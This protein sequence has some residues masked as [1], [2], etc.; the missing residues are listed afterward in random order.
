MSQ[1]PTPPEAPNPPPK[2][3][4]SAAAA[5]AVVPHAP[6]SRSGLKNLWANLRAS[7]RFDFPGPVFTKE[8]RSSQRRFSA[9]SVRMVYVLILA[10]ILAIVY[11][12]TKRSEADGV[13]PVRTI[14]SLQ[15]IAPALTVAV[16]WVQAVLLTL[17][18]PSM[19]AGAFSDERR[20]RTLDVLLTSPIRPWQI[21]IGKLFSGIAALVVLSLCAL[22]VLLA[23]RVFGGIDELF[24]LGSFA[25]CLSLGAL[26][27]S[28]AMLNSF[29]CSK[30]STATFLAFI[31][32]AII[33]GL[34][35][36]AVAIYASAVGGPPAGAFITVLLCSAPVSIFG[37][38]V[39]FIG[40]GGAPFSPWQAIVT[41]TTYNLVITAF[42]VLLCTVILRRVMLSLAAGETAT[43]AIGRVAIRKAA[44]RAARLPGVPE[45]RPEE[46]GPVT[47]L[48]GRRV[49]RVVGDYPV[50]WRELAQ[51][52]FRKPTLGVLTIIFLTVVTIFTYILATMN[53][54][55]A[56]Q[57]HLYVSNFIL[58]SLMLLQGASLTSAGFPGEREAKTWETLLTTPLSGTDLVLSKF[59]GAL[60]GMWFLPGAL[61][62]NLA[63]LGVISGHASPIIIL[64]TI[65]I[66]AG[67]LVFLAAC[68]VRF[69]LA[70]SSSNASGIRTTSAA[71]G[72]WAGLPILA[73]VAALL[74]SAYSL[75]ATIFQTLQR[76]LLHT[77]LYLNPLVNFYNALEGANLTAYHHA[78]YLIADVNVDIGATRF[79]LALLGNV[80]IYFA[81]AALMLWWS[82][83]VFARKSGRA[84]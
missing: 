78:K 72:L 84:S 60:K 12:S 16:L 1:A 15:Q 5:H 33:H 46:P 19:T 30:S 58:V 79:T 8:I 47:K 13:S 21:V 43:V 56:P 41:G 64:H 68:G 25:L 24:I 50:L 59:A 14:Q 31:F 26:V 35:L 32:F 55:P 28:L 70:A 4:A 81:A 39:D 42:I 6:R 80:L 61:L 77:A 71:L 57:A 2:P 36:L 17:M 40:G 53:R 63:T 18:A 22:P 37:M 20:K 54:F 9:F 27:A 62:A 74:V 7:F 52:L 11:S 66:F 83:A 23:V 75:E 38:T 29:W 10:A 44:P 45:E 73:G 67:P 34:P 51:P 3:V 69:S 49:S 48:V 76:G 65:L 82:V